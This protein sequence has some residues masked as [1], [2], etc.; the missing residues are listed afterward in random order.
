MGEAREVV[1]QFVASERDGGLS[2]EGFADLLLARLRG[3]GFM[4]VHPAS[5]SDDCDDP[6]TCCIH[7]PPGSRDDGGGA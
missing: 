2:D 4:V 3:A 7:L 6:W 5:S 1:T